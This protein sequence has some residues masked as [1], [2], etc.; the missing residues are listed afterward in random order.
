MA[1]SAQQFQIVFIGGP[2]LQPSRPIVLAS[3]GF[4]FSIGVFVV[5]VQ[6]AQIVIAASDAFAAEFLDQL[7]LALPI[8]LSFFCAIAVL[9]P[10]LLLT[11]GRAK[12]SFGGLPTEGAVASIAPTVSMVTGH[13]TKSALAS[14]HQIGR[15]LKSLLAMFAN[16]GN[17]GALSHEYIVPCLS[18]TCKPM[19]CEIDPGYYAIAE[20]RIRQAQQQPPL[21]GAQS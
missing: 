10:V 11:F 7:K 12:P 4:D 20:R 21:W 5:Y 17:S 9:V 16:L 1:I 15:C 3:F 8:A 2:I 13:T 18:D 19:N 6:H 14:F